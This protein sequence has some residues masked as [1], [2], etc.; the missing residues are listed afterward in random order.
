MTSSMA[1]VLAPMDA[2]LAYSPEKMWCFNKVSHRS[3][4][5]DT[6]SSQ[7]F[8]LVRKSESSTNC[9]LSWRES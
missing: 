1:P 3:S 5:A 6:A 8:S 2:I 4:P 9:K 7:A